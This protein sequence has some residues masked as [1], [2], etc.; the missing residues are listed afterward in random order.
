[1][2]E[3]DI[4]VGDV[5]TKFTLIVIDNYTELPM[6]ISDAFVKKIEFT[7]PD[8]TLVEVNASFTT[9]GDD[10]S[11]VYTVVDGLFLNVPGTWYYRAYVE[12]PGGLRHTSRAK[13]VVWP[14]A[15]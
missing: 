1:M 5:G 9:N 14:L 7:K 8:G 6:D 2:D 12:Y 4:H 15:S 11:L 10:G 3:K 13:F